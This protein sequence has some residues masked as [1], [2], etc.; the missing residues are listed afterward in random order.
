MNRGISFG[1]SVLVLASTCFADVPPPPPTGAPVTLEVR[2]A[3]SAAVT[4]RIPANL[5]KSTR[6]GFTDADDNGSGFRTAVAGVLLS[7][8]LAVAGVWLVRR[9]LSRPA[10]TAM[11]LTA[12]T[13]AGAGVTLA[14]LG[15]AGPRRRPG[16][17]VPLP[18]SSFA[19]GT[20]L[21]LRDAL[22]G[23]ELSGKVSVEI[24]PEGQP[25]TLIIPAPKPQR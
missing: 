3:P 7:L 1:L 9:K 11:I 23:G 5:L 19:P 12:L 17:P 2:S 16:P 20:L 24:V 4:L 13:L 21:K 18:I 25:I 14:D 22:G 6:A 10:Q 15:G 8:S